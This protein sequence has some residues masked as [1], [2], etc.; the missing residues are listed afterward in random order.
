MK[1]GAAQARPRVRSPSPKARLGVAWALGVA[2]TVVAAPAQA[3][4]ELEL[5]A[6]ANFPVS[7]GLEAQIELPL[8]MLARVHV[9]WMPPAHVSVINAVATGFDWYDDATADLVSAAIDG[10]LV[11]RLSGGWRPV[12]TWGLEVSAGY[13]LITGGGSVTSAEALEIATGQSVS[14]RANADIPLEATL[15]GVHVDAGWRWRLGKMLSIRVALG[16]FQT[17]AASTALTVGRGRLQEPISRAE[18]YLDTILETYAL[19][20]ELKVSVG[21]TL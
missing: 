18:A 2:S 10:A 17:L 16:Y 7:L 9:G 20:P 15:Q 8:R 14:T 5:A 13:T 12:D 6:G 3:L 11:L 4:P 19:A 1:R 21:Y